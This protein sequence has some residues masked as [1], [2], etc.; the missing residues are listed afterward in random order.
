M[1][2]DEISQLDLVTR[3][4]I[5]QVQQLGERRLIDNQISNGF[6]KL[7]LDREIPEILRLLEEQS[8]SPLIRSDREWHRNLN[9]FHSFLT[10][11]FYDNIAQLLDQLFAENKIEK[12]PSG[13]WLGNRLAE[14]SADLA[15]WIYKRLT[16]E[17]R[18]L[19][20]L[21]LSK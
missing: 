20:L 1:T 12:T 2:L 3:E 4:R 9:P 18:P 8:N 16:E 21:N 15:Q 19:S 10:E 14:G 17:G 5:R 11:L 6:L 13:W 7:V